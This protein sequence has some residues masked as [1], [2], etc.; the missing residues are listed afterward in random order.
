MV[1]FLRLA[2]LAVGLDCL[3]LLILLPYFLGAE[4]TGL[5]HRKLAIPLFP[6]LLPFV[7]RV[8]TL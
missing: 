1:S 7:T 3:E 4:V 5:Y 6:L 2:P 8:L